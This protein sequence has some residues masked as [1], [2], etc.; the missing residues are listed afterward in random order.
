M[1]TQTFNTM[2]GDFDL[3]DVVAGRAL[4]E[5]DERTPVQ[6]F[7][8]RLTNAIR[9]AIGKDKKELSIEDARRGLDKEA[10][11]ALKKEQK[12]QSKEIN[13]LI[14]SNSL[15]RERI[16]V[17]KGENKSL[18]EKVEKAKVKGAN[19]KTPVELQKE[20]DRL[21]KDSY[22]RMMLPVTNFLEAWERKKTVV[23][24]D[25]KAHNGTGY[26][27]GLVYLDL[28]LAPGE[29]VKTQDEVGRKI[30]IQGTPWGNVVFFQRYQ[31]DEHGYTPIVTNAPDEVRELVSIENTV[32]VRTIDLFFPLDQ[33]MNWGAVAQ[34]LLVIEAKVAAEALRKDT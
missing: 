9:S 32:D 23:E 18:S 1:T 17:L 6:P 20:L 31:P 3:N 10:I 5:I 27:D 14:E 30:L 22:A 24:F 15:L 13:T 7:T 4:V 11:A 26:F 19:N 34:R 12:A 21:K 16:G 25:A 33:A 28:G 8:K 29:V 2:F